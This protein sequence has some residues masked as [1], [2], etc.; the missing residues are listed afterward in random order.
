MCRKLHEYKSQS[1]LLFFMRI[2]I[3][4]VIIISTR[5]VFLRKWRHIL[6]SVWYIFS[7]ET[8]THLRKRRNKIIQISANRPLP[9]YLNALDQTS[10]GAILSHENE[11]SFTR[12]SNSFSCEWLSNSLFLIERFKATR[13][14]AITIR[15]QNAVTVMTSLVQTWWIINE[16]EEYCLLKTP[17]GYVCRLQPSVSCRMTPW[18]S[19]ITYTTSPTLRVVAA[20]TFWLRI[21][22]KAKSAES[23]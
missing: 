16:L 4:I 15:Y 7:I 12:K 21:T 19:L 1:F 17:H 10:R 5:V 6:F 20:L 9:N 23:W 13:K 2:V 22:G 8:E 11:I 3:L 18:G 14:W